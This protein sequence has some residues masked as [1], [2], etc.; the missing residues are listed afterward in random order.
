MFQVNQC[1]LYAL[2]KYGMDY[3]EFKSL[4]Y[5]MMHTQLNT[6]LNTIPYGLPKY[7]CFMLMRQCI[8]TFKINENENINKSG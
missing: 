4:S 2:K 6:Y 1:L 5:V 8:L 7:E 3:D